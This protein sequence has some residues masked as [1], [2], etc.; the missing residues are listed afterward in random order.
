MCNTCLHI[1]PPTPFENMMRILA[2]L[3]LSVRDLVLRFCGVTRVSFW[4]PWASEGRIRERIRHTHRDGEP[5]AIN[6]RKQNKK[7]IYEY[8]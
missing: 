5:K 8:T 6:K 4:D 3:L 2:D 1:M 7:N